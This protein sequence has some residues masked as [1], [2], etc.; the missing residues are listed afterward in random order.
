MKLAFSTFIFA[1]LIIF[2]CTKDK[3]NVCSFESSY[4]ND[5]I[6]FFNDY[7]ISCHQNGNNSGGVVLDNH[8]SVE[9]HINK[10]ITE[11]Q[12]LSMPPYGMPTATDNER[13]SILEKLNCWAVNGTLNN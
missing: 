5:L 13:D 9:Q 1:I 12:S 4:S 3:T 8:A 2:S 11:I 6:P 7:C 10:I